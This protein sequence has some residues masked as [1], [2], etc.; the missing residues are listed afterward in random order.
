VYYEQPRYYRESAVVYV[1]PRGYGYRDHGYDRGH[2]RGHDGWD[3][4][5]RGGR[6]WDRDGRG[7]RHDGYRR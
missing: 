6:D 7:D 1:A 2:G 3:R 5:G 4:D